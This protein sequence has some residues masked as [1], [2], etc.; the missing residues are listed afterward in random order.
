[1]CRPGRHHAAGPLIVVLSIALAACGSGSSPGASPS[2]TATP[3][4]PSPSPG[5]SAFNL[6]VVPTTFT[7]LIHSGANVVLLVTVDGQPS[8]GP[9]AIAASVEGAQA[10][11][12][13]AQLVPGAVAEVTVTGL[14]CPSV[15]DQAKA[16]VRIVATR[17]SV[18]RTET[19]E[20]TL[21]AEVNQLEQEARAHLAPF[22]EWLAKQRPDLGI[23]A[24]TQWESVPAP[25]V[26]IVEHHL[27]FSKDWELDISW[28][29]MI[30]PDDWSMIVLRHRGTELKP[31]LAFKID[32]VS[33]KTSPHEVAVP[34]AVWR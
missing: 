10:K 9:V 1:M 3:I 24:S 16:E 33:G 26:L 2:D 14:A 6:I 13:P 15:C 17:G 20:M 25:W 23:S 19:R 21:T 12:E 28:H 34:D 30:P 32:S 27:F 18:S 5:S 4:P 7:G 22:V 11:V 8:D 31:S 29:V